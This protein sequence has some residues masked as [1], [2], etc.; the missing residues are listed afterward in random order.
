MKPARRRILDHSKSPASPVGGDQ[1]SNLLASARAA[2]AGFNHEDAITH[3]QA[4]LAIAA[5]NVAEQAAARCLL[6]ESL[7]VVKK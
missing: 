6:A 7:G 5:S 2:R 3:C 4:A 1:L